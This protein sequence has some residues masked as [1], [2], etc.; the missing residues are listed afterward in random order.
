MGQLNWVTDPHLDFLSEDALTTFVAE[1]DAAEGDA[2]LISGASPSAASTS[3]T[4]VVN[5]SS[6][7]KSR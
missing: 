1:V 2:L 3:A 7:R 5:A 6:L 4:K